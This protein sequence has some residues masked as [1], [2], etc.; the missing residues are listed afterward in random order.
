MSKTTNIPIDNTY[1]PAPLYHYRG[2]AAGQEQ[3]LLDELVGN[4][5]YLYWVTDHYVLSTRR[6]FVPRLDDEVASYGQYE[7]VGYSRTHLHLQQ[8]IVRHEEK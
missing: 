3:H 4:S 6:A 2:N 5:Y 1:G 7:V 8:A